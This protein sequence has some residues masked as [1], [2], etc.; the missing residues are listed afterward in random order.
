MI[1][2]HIDCLSAV[3][4]NAYGEVIRMIMSQADSIPTAGAEGLGDEGRMNGCHASGQRKL[5]TANT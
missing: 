1:M 4:T 3:G 5:E 2:P